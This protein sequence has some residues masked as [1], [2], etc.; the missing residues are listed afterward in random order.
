MKPMGGKEHNTYHQFG[1]AIV[2]ALGICA[3]GALLIWALVE[4]HTPSSERHMH[5]AGMHHDPV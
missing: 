5:D 1:T 4:T 2:L 3:L